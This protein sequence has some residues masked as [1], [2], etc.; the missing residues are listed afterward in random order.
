[1][2]LSIDISNYE[3]Y[4]MDYI[5]GELSQED[6]AHF[7]AFLMKHPDVAMEVEELMGSDFSLE[8]IEDFQ[9]KKS[10]TIEI[11]SI[12]G[13]DESNYEEAMAASVDSDIN[14][15]LVSDLDDFVEANPKLKRDLD[16][17]RATKLVPSN[18][19]A[20]AGK[21]NLKKS[22][23]LF[24]TSAGIY[25]IAAAVLI[26][27]GI[28]GLLNTIQNEI[29]IPR[30]GAVDSASLFIELPTAHESKAMRR[31]KVAALVNPKS[32]S[33]A[34]RKSIPKMDRLKALKKWAPQ[35]L[36][37]REK[38]SFALAVATEVSE[39]L[40]AQNERSP[41]LNITQFVGKELLGLAP[42]KTLTINS[43]LREGAKK[44]IDQSEQFALNTTSDDKNKKT[45][46]MLAGAVEFKR[47]R[48]N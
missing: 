1:M 27:F 33:L 28:I 43:L 45:F 40:V 47:V 13:I 34:S 8:P 23:P 30:R 2:S 48:Y 16:L 42:E 19:L 7:E 35:T 5:D 29:Y 31:S 6:K 36:I 9:D 26:L 18:E 15:G 10:L 20:F 39:V 24:A 3:L 44:V 17:Y 37:L 32:V 4:V 41:E 21:S 38:S 14:L 12:A 11:I 22:I 46:S 25:R